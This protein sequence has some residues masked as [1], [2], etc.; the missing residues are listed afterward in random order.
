MSRRRDVKVLRPKSPMDRRLA[1]LEQMRVWEYV[2]QSVVD[3]A[4]AIDFLKRLAE[5]AYGLSNEP[6]ATQTF[7]VRAMQ[8]SAD[9]ID[10]AH[11][12]RKETFHDRTIPTL[13]R[14]DVSEAMQRLPGEDEAQPRQGDELAAFREQLGR[15]IASLCRARMVGVVQ[16]VLPSENGDGTDG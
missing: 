10:K 5:E 3:D 16:P 8:A 1:R 7:R 4:D 9:F 12:I 2:S 11:K 14:I 13:Q 15:D 6:G